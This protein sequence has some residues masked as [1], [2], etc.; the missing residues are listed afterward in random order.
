[1]GWVG[2]NWGVK[3]RSEGKRKNYQGREGI[4][5]ER[6]KGYTVGL[7]MQHLK[8]AIVRVQ[9]YLLTNKLGAQSLHMKY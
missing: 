8:L 1:M 9:L 6:F 5:Y 2:K 4:K 3:D 7:S